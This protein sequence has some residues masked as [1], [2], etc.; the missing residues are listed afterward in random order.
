[1]SCKS[2]V[3]LSDLHFHSINSVLVI[4]ILNFNAVN[5][6]VFSSVVRSFV[7]C[8]GKLSLQGFEDS[9][10]YYILEDLVFSF[11]KRTLVHLE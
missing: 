4:E 9:L 2:L 6:L 3:F 1:M 11:A 10:L 7:S 5:I 8:L